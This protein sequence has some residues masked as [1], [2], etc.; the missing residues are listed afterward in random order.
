MKKSTLAAI[1]VAGS[2]LGFVGCNQFKAQST[3]WEYQIVTFD[4]GSQDELN[5]L[6]KDGWELVS[7]QVMEQNGSQVGFGQGYLKRP[8]EK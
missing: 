2:L 6:G 7:V 4:S 8:L 5:K 3:K 1:F